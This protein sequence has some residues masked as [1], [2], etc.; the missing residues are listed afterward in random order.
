[1]NK[2]TLIILA[3]FLFAPF[4]QAAVLDSDKDGLS[5]DQELYIY[6]TNPAAAD[7]DGDGYADGGEVNNG[8]SPSSSTPGVRIV[9]KIE[10]DTKK[11]ELTYFADGMRIWTYRVST[12]KASMPTPKGEFKIIN[13]HPRPWSKKYGLWMPFWMGIK[14]GSYGLHEL[15]EWPNGYKEGANHLG[16]PVSHGCIRLGVGDAKKIYDWAPV[17]TRVVIK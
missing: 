16:I 14:D 1:M 3:F 17:G 4:A 10:I 6:K 15:P 8:F 12:G 7:S 2:F 13:K 9:K 11:Q 5:D